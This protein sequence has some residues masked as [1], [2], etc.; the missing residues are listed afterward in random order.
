[1]WDGIM[2]A[3]KAIVM[4]L[5]ISLLSGCG[6]MIFSV[7]NAP[8]TLSEQNVIRNIDFG[9]DYEQ[10]LNVYLPDNDEKNRDVIIFFM[11]GHG[12]MV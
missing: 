9:S 3:C 7:V 12:K 11:E 4:L 2:R 1:L 6:K 10:T 5:S 8:N